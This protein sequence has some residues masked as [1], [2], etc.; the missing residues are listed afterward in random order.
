MA[1][2]DINMLPLYLLKNET[3]KD[4]LET[5][6]E[7]FKLLEK[8]ALEVRDELNITTCN[9]LLSRYERI[10]NVTPSGDRE[11]RINAIL[12]KRFTNFNNTPENIE[13]L[14]SIIAKARCE[15]NEHFADY[16]FDVLVYKKGLLLSE[17]IKISSA[18]EE[19]KP[20]HLR[21][22]VIPSKKESLRIN[23]STKSYKIVGGLIQV[24]AGEMPSVSMRGVR[25]KS[26][27]DIK[28]DNIKA[29]YDSELCGIGVKKGISLKKSLIPLV[30]T[31][32]YKSDVSY[33][34]VKYCGEGG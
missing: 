1:V 32:S 7:E 24:N 27:L 28:N 8:K 25:K 29:K 12:I 6:Q 17:M 13:S 9:K 19:L 4:L 11:D 23:I 14:A 5:E 34:G 15:V 10:Y 26:T 16:S 18:I 3:M 20:A 33:A 2:N 21:A 31:S 22:Y 30:S